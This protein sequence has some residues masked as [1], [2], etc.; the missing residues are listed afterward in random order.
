[1][2]FDNADVDFDNADVYFM[3]QTPQ[4]HVLCLKKYHSATG[5]SWWMRGRFELA[6]DWILDNADV[7]FDNADVEFRI[8]D[9]QK[10]NIWLWSL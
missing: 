8:L 3:I 4:K 9:P 6:G 1:M 2:D 10:Q 7:D 5:R